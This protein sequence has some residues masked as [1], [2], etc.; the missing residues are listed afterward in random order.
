MRSEKV[1]AS[2]AGSRP[3]FKR[4]KK[5]VGRRAPKKLNE[6]DTTFKTKNIVVREQSL[7]REKLRA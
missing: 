2:G 6:T 3:D 4:I 1:S 7:C 5:K